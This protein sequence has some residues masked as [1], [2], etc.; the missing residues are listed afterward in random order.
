MQ[1]VGYILIKLQFI[2]FLIIQNCEEKTNTTAMNSQVGRSLTVALY[3]GTRAW[4]A[5]GKLEAIF[6]IRET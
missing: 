3:C 4:V 5:M 6:L 1:L 2:L